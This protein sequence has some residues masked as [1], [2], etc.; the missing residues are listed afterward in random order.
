MSRLPEFNV[1]YDVLVSDVY[2][3]AGSDVVPMQY[4]NQIIMNPNSEVI[5]RDST[6]HNM[7]LRFWYISDKLAFNSYS[8]FLYTVN[9]KDIFVQGHYV[10]QKCGLITS[11]ASEYASYKIINDNR[12]TEV[13]TFKRIIVQMELQIDKP[14]WGDHILSKGFLFRHPLTNTL[15]RIQFSSNP[16]YFLKNKYKYPDAINVFN[17]Y[18]FYTEARPDL[19]I[20]SPICLDRNGGILTDLTKPCY[21]DIVYRDQRSW[22]GLML[23][24]IGGM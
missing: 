20:N 15:K 9:D 10:K 23:P 3:P 22:E 12:Q 5:A 13:V 14:V 11:I 16:E 8:K 7:K 24:S 6:F 18:G 2:Y 1:A 4:D 21:I 19:N 17:G